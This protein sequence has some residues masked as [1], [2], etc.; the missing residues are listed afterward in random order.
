[1]GIVVYQTPLHLQPLV[2]VAALWDQTSYVVATRKAA[3]KALDIL[4]YV[5]Q[6]EISVVLVIIAALVNLSILQ[7]TPTAELQANL[8]A[9]VAMSVV[10]VTQ[11]V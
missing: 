1:M 4:Q 7:L 2:R 6:T 5:L 8:V 3:M 11:P 10:L 9:L